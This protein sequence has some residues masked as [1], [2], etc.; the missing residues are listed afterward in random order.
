MALSRGVAA[1]LLACAV[2]AGTAP[3]QAQRGAHADPDWPCVQ[4]KTPSFGLASVWTGEA[5]DV[6]SQAWRDDP[7]TARLV[8]LMTQR[9]TPAA[10]VEAA[11][12]AFA[13]KQ[14]AEGRPK[15]L[16]A[17][18][19]AFAEL[20]AQRAQVMEGLARFGRKQTQMAEAIRRENE[21]L[22]AGQGAV[23]GPAGEPSPALR[24]LQWDIRLFEERKRT[25]GYVCETPALIEQRIG[26]VARAVAQATGAP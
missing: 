13:S 8:A 19:G 20:S 9:R 26:L 3:A 21:A 11:I 7:D 15:L 5:L 1:A 2:I 4:I 18:A 25:I 12:A 24:K 23:A 16:A 10:E 22:H 6:T 17:F 14:G